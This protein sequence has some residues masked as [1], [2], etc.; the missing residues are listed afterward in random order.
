MKENLVKYLK[1]IS[2]GEVNPG[3]TLVVAFFV[4][5]LF[6]LVPAILVWGLQMMGFGVSLNIKS[7]MGAILVIVIL[8]I[9]GGTSGT[10]KN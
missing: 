6:A 7:W 2:S 3:V 10:K 8:K 9:V 4:I 1:K 5:C